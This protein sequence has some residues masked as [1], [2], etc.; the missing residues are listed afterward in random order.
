[1]I[2]GQEARGGITSYYQTLA[3]LFK[4]HIDYLERGARKW[5]N[6]E[7]IF[8][9]TLRI[10]TDLFRFIKVISSKKYSL[11]LTN[12]SFSLNSILRDGL[13]LIVARLFR[14]KTVVFFHGWNYKFAETT[15]GLNL[16]LFKFIY[17]K[18]DAIIDLA[19]RNIVLLKEWGYNKPI[20]LGTMVV[21]N[22]LVIQLNEEQIIEKFYKEKCTI[23]F[24]ARIE[25]TKGIYE[26]L[27]TY[28][29]LKKKYKNLGMTIAGDGGEVGNLRAYIDEKHL[30]D[31]KL[32]GFV[33]DK[34]KIA[35]FNDSQIYLFPSY[36]EGMPTSLL[37]AMAFGLPV[38]TR[39]VGGISD[40][41][42]D[43]KNG[44]ITESKDPVVLASLIEKIL[45]NK[46]L[47]IAIGL[48]NYRFAKEHFLSKEVVKRME[49]ILLSVLNG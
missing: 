17:F 2:P 30:A 49:N 21:D 31:I 1:M 9:K 34:S 26:A 46:N 11:V 36:F 19:Q 32:L 43:E 12:T 25:K 47:A 48:N 18:S 28:A 35:A 33:K 24:L 15:K 7:D 3:P 13:F 41:F 39:N 8:L 6:K 38:I 22:N 29:I 5:P 23:L 45:S 40:F 20:F 14:I 10:L 27:D 44:F 16:M 42:I 4:L 37:E